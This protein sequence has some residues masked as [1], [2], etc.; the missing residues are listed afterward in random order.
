MNIHAFAIKQ[1]EQLRFRTARSI[2]LILAAVGLTAFT[3]VDAADTASTTNPSDAEIAMI[4]V[5]ADTVDVNY[6]KLAVEKTKNQAVKEFAET[7]VRDH[8]SVNEKAVAL[9]KK[10]GV[11]PAASKTSKSLESNGEAELKKLKALTDSHFDK[12]TWPTKWPIMKPSL[13]CSTK[14]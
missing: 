9:A 10:L 4:V 5:V 2:V 6:G 12:R 8:T 1:I 14:R 3:T 11:T 13:T 7:M